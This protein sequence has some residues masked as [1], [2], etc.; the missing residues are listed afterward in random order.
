MIAKRRVAAYVLSVIALPI[1]L[2]YGN[3]ALALLTAAAIS[4]ILNVNP[5]PLP[6]RYGRLALQAAIVML[7]LR[8]DAG[9]MLAL[10][11]DY[12][13]LV[14]GYVLFTLAAGLSL[15]RLLGCDLGATRLIAAGT[16]ICGGT[17]IATLSPIIKAPAEQTGVVLALVFLL[18]A[19]ALFCLP[20]IGHW[21]EL[22]QLEFGLWAA[23]AI[24]DTSS[25]VATAAIYGEE[26]AAVATTIKLGRTLWLIPLVVL[27]SML[28][29]SP[30]A[31]IRIPGFVILFVLASLAGSM[32]PLPEIVPEIAKLSSSML[33][34][35]ALFCLGAEISRD[36][37]QKL[38]GRVLVVGV[39]LWAIVLPASLAVIL[40]IT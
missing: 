25:V 2:W 31:K 23:L 21:L 28:E 5:V 35:I 15:G 19:V 27:Y 14:G 13:L 38:R 34:V 29:K 26:A 12:A 6:S 40:S 9:Q 20:W 17:A 10:S 8:L 39:G 32:L 37:L 33:L 16:S 1:L 4:V 3:P 22:S 18:N 30:Q 24:H 11:S 36:T 7:G